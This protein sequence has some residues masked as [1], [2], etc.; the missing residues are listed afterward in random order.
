VLSSVACYR[1]MRRVYQ[2]AVS[3]AEA[4]TVRDRQAVG[5]SITVP[6]DALPPGLYTCQANVVDDIAG[7]FAFPRFPLY[8]SSAAVAGASR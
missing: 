4:V 2:T 3:A 1:G 7:R 6:P 5:V 8:V